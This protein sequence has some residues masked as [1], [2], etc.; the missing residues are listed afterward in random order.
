VVLYA[1]RIEREDAQ[2]VS[3]SEIAQGWLAM[4]CS[5]HSQVFAT[6]CKRAL[7]TLAQHR[8]RRDA[9]GASEITHLFE[10]IGRGV[11]LVGRGK[12]RIG[13]EQVTDW[14][15]TIDREPQSRKHEDMFGTHE[16]RKDGRRSRWSRALGVWDAAV[17]L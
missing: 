15:R 4:P 9:A 8:K 11:P 17:L 6:S 14:R 7:L 12:P 3:R 1:A 16:G 2:E 5:K 13:R 10:A